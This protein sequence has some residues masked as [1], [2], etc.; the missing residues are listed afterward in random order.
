VE[1]FCEGPKAEV[2]AP[3][4]EREESLL[5]PTIVLYEVYKKLLREKGATTAERFLSYAFRLDN[6][7]I[8]LDADMALSAARTSLQHN[9]GMAD[10]IIYATAQLFHAELVTTDFDFQGKP[11]VTMV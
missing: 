5:L 3:Y 6:R 1:Y 2:F 8:A 7:C 4:L 9:L 11:G 10:A